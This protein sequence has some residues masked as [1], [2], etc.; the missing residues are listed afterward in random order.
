V[1]PLGANVASGKKPNHVVSNLDSQL[2]SASQRH[3]R[4]CKDRQNDMNDMDQHK[5]DLNQILA[6]HGSLPGTDIGPV[7]SESQLANIE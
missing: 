5:K 7:I 3:A 4:L 1:S 6:Q 2:E